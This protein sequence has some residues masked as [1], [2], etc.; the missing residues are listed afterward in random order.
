M[1]LAAVFAAEA[2]TLT[3][4]DIVIIVAIAIIVNLVMRRL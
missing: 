2:V 4:V 3:L 1:M